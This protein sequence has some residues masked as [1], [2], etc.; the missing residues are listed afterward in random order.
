MLSLIVRRLRLI[1]KAQE[2]RS[3]GMPKKEIEARL[4]IMPRQAQEF[5]DQ[6][7]RFPLSALQ[8]LWPPTLQADRELKSSRADKG[9]LLEKYLW[10]ISLSASGGDR[11][12]GGKINRDLDRKNDP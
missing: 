9:L 6:A 10:E 11:K 4:R 12:P 2:L 7:E 5:W 1:R 8:Q 3:R